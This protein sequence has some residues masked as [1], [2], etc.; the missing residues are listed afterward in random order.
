MGE[1]M[2]ISPKEVVEYWQ[3][4]YTKL[5]EQSVGHCADSIEEQ[6]KVVQTKREF[7]RDMLPKKVRNRKLQ[8]LDFGCGTGRMCSLFHPAHYQGVDVVDYSEFPKDYPREIVT[9]VPPAPFWDVDMVFTANVLQHNSDEGVSKILAW[10]AQSHPLWLFIYECTDTRARS[11][12]C[13]GRSLDDY[14]RLVE[15]NFEVYAFAHRTHVPKEGRSTNSA[16]LWR[17]KTGEG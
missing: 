5:G 16:M 17:I 15:E 6:H 4:Q 2:G 11:A 14:D 12:N 1:K 10:M 8:V 7:I 13:V 9:T 3:Q